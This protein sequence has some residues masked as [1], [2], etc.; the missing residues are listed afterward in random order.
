[1]SLRPSQSFCSE[2]LQRTMLTSCGRNSF[3]LNII[4]YLLIELP[5]IGGAASLF[6]VQHGSNL[7]RYAPP[8]SPAPAQWKLRQK[9][10]V[11]TIAR[12]YVPSAKVSHASQM[13][14]LLRTG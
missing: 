9:W 13:L 4:K 10:P 2:R 6:G 7:S 14:A 5:G 12:T 8:P 11:G 3:Y 1:M